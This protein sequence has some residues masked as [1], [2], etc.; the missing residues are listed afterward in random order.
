MGSFKPL[1][2]III[3]VYNGSNFMK[4]AIDSAIS[5]T[6]QNIE[7]IVVNDGSTDTTDEIALSY[8]EKIRYFKKENGG[9]SSAL[10]L[11]IENMKGE[12]F[13]WLSHDDVYTPDK[14]EKSI[15][16]L[17][18]CEDKNTLIYCASKK[19][20]KNSMPLTDGPANTD[21]EYINWQQAI[22]EM[23][24]KGTY[25][26]CA[27]LIPKRA[28]DVCGGFSEEYRFIQ[29]K[30]VWFNFFFNKFSIL[31]IPDVCVMSRIHGGQ[32][33]QTGQELFRKESY[34]AS[35]Y[36]ISELLKISSKENNLI[37]AYI[38]YNAKY[39]VSNVVKNAVREAEKAKLLNPMDVLQIFVKCS[40]G[41][42]RP[43]IRRLYYKFFRKIKTS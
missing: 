21:K 22:F 17:E 30:M 10:N 31:K 36:M 9:V 26:G 4:E 3:P 15:N 5:Q 33:T 6:Y 39:N 24:E 38:L 25:G 37:K 42:I 28:F 34:E 43:F 11:G 29:D 41:K 14:I 23:F 18:L 16:A 7:V 20:D 19:I 12:Y 32:L 2:S 27:F 35:D 1:V 8:G 13:S 40:Y